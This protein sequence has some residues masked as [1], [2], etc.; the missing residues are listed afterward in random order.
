VICYFRI[1][2]VYRYVEEAMKEKDVKSVVRLIG[3]GLYM[4][5]PPV[6]P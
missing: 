4:L 5:N 2:L 6:D 1:R 3:V